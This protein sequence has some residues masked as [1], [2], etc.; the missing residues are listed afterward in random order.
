MESSIFKGNEGIKFMSKILKVEEAI[1]IAKKIREQNKSI[2]LTGGCFDILHVGHIIFL[3]KAKQQGDVLFVLLE[4]DGNVRRF[5]GKD[6]PIN[7]QK[8][9]AVVLCA[10]KVVDYVV[11]LKIMTRNHQYDTIV[12]Q[13]RPSIIAT[14]ISDKNVKHKKRQAKKINAKVVYVTKRILN[15]ST[16]QI[17]NLTKREII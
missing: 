8:N 2:V 14:T 4:S 12:S 7:S 9:R 6:R 5:K 15:Q 10:L 3:E 17:A 1:K 13:I 16:T 11:M